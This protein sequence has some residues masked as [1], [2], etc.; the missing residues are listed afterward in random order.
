MHTEIQEA[1]LKGRSWQA[2]SAKG[3][4]VDPV[5]SVGFRVSVTTI[6]ISF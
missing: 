3:Q 5:G 4:A 1:M 2:V 6:K